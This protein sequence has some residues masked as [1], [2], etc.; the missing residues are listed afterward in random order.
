MTNTMAANSSR[1]KRCRC[2]RSNR[3]KSLLGTI[4]LTSQV[5]NSTSFS[6]PFST[7]AIQLTS[8]NH[9]TISLA[10][11]RYNY[12]DDDEDD[13]DLLDDDYEPP[14]RRRY[15]DLGTPPLT[16]STSD[17]SLDIPSAFGRSSGL[18]LPP[19]VSSA[20]LA[21]VFV[22]GIGTRVTV[23]SQINTNPK[24][25]ASRDA[26]DKNVPNPNMAFDQ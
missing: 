2:T 25:L 10:K 9:P 26:V 20:L 11:R 4:F 1:S 15:N 21:G 23:G 22:L 8:H 13:W 12:D 16:A 5:Q 6:P 14:R 19:S 3:T 24:D 17:T 7:K 18:R